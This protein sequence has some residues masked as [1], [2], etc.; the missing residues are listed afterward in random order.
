LESASITAQKPCL[1]VKAGMILISFLPAGAALFATAGEF[2][3]GG[4]SPC[5][6][7]F[8]AET[9]LLVAFFDVGRLTL[10]FVSVTGFIA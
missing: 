3:Y 10:L 2:V 1:A 7:G 5:L 4:P 9:L 8:R 6:G